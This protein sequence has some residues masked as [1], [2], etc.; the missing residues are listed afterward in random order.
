M[1][2]LNL[3][4]A[5]QKSLKQATAKAL[6][7]VPYTGKSKDLT[8]A[9][10]PLVDEKTRQAAIDRILEK[11]V[12]GYAPGVPGAKTAAE[13]MR[14]MQYGRQVSAYIPR[15]TGYF[16]GSH[17]VDGVELVPGAPGYDEAKALP[18]LQKQIAP[19]N[20]DVQNYLKD[21]G[22]YTEETDVAVKAQEAKQAEY[23]KYLELAKSG[24]MT[25]YQAEA[26]AIDLER[27]QPRTDLPDVVKAAEPA[28]TDTAQTA[29]EKSRAD[30]AAEERRLQEAA[31]AR[32]RARLRRARPL[33][34]EQRL[35]PELQL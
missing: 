11:P 3:S 6:R 26:A 34:S 14:K 19:L 30:L 29:L 24:Q 5:A 17:K 25:G 12:I 10:L 33:L 9:M 8:E 18:I 4:P 32:Q 2:I 15:P 7:S 27:G 28:T 21:I 22:K 35:A 16:G 20:K 1:A 13:T 23:D 31:A